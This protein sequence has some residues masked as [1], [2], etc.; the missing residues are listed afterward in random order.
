MNHA[1]RVQNFFKVAVNARRLQS[2]R[3]LET[4]P[5]VTENKVRGV[6]I[7]VL[8]PSAFIVKQSLPGHRIIN[9]QRRVYL[10]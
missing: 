6:T 5:K 9:D 10:D 2:K 8:F 4:F 7:C 1:L 3:S